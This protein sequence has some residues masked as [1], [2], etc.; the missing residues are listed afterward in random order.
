MKTYKGVRKMVRVESLGT[1][2]I[3]TGQLK[4]TKKEIEINTRVL[5][6]NAN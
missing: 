1:V 4:N 6:Q 5:C 3:H 2:Y